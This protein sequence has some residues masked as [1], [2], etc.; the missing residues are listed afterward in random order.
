MNASAR[1][2]ERSASAIADDSAP[3]PA[4]ASAAPRISSDPIINA[5]H[6]RAIEL[7]LA[8]LFVAIVYLSFVPFDF[9]GHRPARIAGHGRIVLG[10][11]TAPY[12]IPDILANIAYYAPLGALG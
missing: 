3:Q 2:G 8:A 12:N 10:L 5:I 9:T 7:C 4:P 11:G 1:P 6:G